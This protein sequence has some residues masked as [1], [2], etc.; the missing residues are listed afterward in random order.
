MRYKVIALEY[1][2]DGVVPVGVP[3][4]ILVLLGTDA[5]DEQITAGILVKTAQNVE[6]GGLAAARR[7]QHRDEF[8]LTESEAHVP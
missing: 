5:V 4:G 6:H 8:A 1:E 3:V 2:T 7:P